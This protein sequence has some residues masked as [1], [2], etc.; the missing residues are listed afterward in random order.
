MLRTFLLLLSLVL[1][2]MPTALRAQADGAQPQDATRVYL[3]TMAPGPEFW[4]VFGH[5]ALIVEY[6]QAPAE[7]YNFGY[8]NFAEPGFLQR[9][10]FGAMQYE[11]VMLPAAGDLG[12]Y[13]AQGRAVTLQELDL[14]V[15]Q[16]QRLVEHLREHVRPENRR[17]RYDYFRNNCSTKLRDALDHATAGAVSAATQRRSHGYT[18]RGLALAQSRDVWWMYLAMHAGLGLAADQT[19]SIREES[20]IPALFMDS[21]RRVQLR[22]AE[23]KTRDLVR[24]EQPFSA[25]LLMPAARTLAPTT[26]HWFALA[27]LCWAGVLLLLPAGLAMAATWVSTL[28]LGLCGLTCAFFW[29]GTAHWGAA[30][31]QNLF[32]FNPLYILLA[33]LWLI[34]ASRRALLPLAFGLL[35]IGVLGSFAKVFPTFGQQNIEWVLLL[36]PVQWAIWRARFRRDQPDAIAASSS[37]VA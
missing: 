30:Y 9:F 37:R 20:Y 32:L 13:V 16:R 22:D 1:Q 10:A 23:G 15:L 6:A 5:N 17:Y 27:G 3:A 31:N 2:C 21:L 25:E 19:L 7:S 28:L 8:F 29:L 24:N 26:W 11:A 33:L 35:V 18:W 4:S 12:H 34:P 36:L 14:D